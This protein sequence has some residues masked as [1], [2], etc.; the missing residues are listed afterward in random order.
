M[1]FETLKEKMVKGDRKRVAE[2]AKCSPYTVDDAL[3]GKQGIKR[4]KAIKALIKLI[5]EREKLQNNYAS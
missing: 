3:A 1:A 4:E 2:K 5:D